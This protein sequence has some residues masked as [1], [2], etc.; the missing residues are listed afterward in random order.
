MKKKKGPGRP[1]ISDEERELRDFRNPPRKCVVDYECIEMILAAENKTEFDFTS[2]VVDRKVPSK[3]Y[4]TPWGV[5]DKL[6]VTDDISLPENNQL[7]LYLPFRD[8]SQEF[9]F[10]SAYQSRYQHQTW[11]VTD[12]FKETREVNSWIKYGASL[13]VYPDPLSYRLKKA[14]TVARNKIVMYLFGDETTLNIDAFKSA[15]VFKNLQTNR[16]IS[17]ARPT[18][19]AYRHYENIK[20]YYSADLR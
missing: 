1:R 16:R 2:Y 17:N 12:I 6:K 9:L 7:R 20:R 5:C 11:I 18:V 15:S 14:T 19:A 3:Y 13:I 4:D 8:A 10:Y